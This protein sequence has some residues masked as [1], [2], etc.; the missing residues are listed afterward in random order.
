MNNID[1]IPT[2]KIQTKQYTLTT[3]IAGT[4]YEGRQKIIADYLKYSCDI[5]HFDRDDPEYIKNSDIEE[6]SNYIPDVHY[7]QYEMEEYDTVSLIPE[8]DNPYD[9]KAIKV[10][11][12]DMGVLGYIPMDDQNKIKDFLN[13]NEK[14]TF[15]LKLKGG[16]YK[17][18][19]EDTYKVKRSISNFNFDLTL[20]SSTN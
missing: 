13:N 15:L 8:P 4:K 2:T 14:I 10:V 5:N 20:M 16:P 3:Y 1:K 19:D 17:Y 11:H 12:N 9:P 18:F 7:Y 6:E